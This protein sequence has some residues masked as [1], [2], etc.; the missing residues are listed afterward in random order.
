M[1][2]CDVTYQETADW[3]TRWG[4]RWPGRSDS[5]CWPHRRRSRQSCNT[6]IL[7]LPQASGG[8]R[9]RPQPVGT[10]WQ[11]LPDLSPPDSHWAALVASSSMTF[12][13]PLSG[14]AGSPWWRA[15]LRAERWEEKSRMQCERTSIVHNL[16]NN[17]NNNGHDESHI[18]SSLNLKH[19][20]RCVVKKWQ[21]TE[22]SIM[23]DDECHFRIRRTFWVS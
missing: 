15:Q 20:G 5:W 23:Y 21:E 13:M 12:W 17:G 6:Y 8:S 22:T 14:L 16:H 3:G 19:T 1:R 4:A 2:L 9:R 11:L 18:S 10:W 7:H